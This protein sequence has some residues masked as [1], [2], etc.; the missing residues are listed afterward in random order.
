[1]KIEIFLIHCPK[2]KKKTQHRIFNISKTR[3][4]KLQCLDCLY[5]KPYY[6]NVLSLKGKETKNDN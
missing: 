5:I 2:C 1:M 3:G 4:Y 6:I